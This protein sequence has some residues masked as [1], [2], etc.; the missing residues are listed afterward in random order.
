MELHNNDVDNWVCSLTGTHTPTEPV[1]DAFRE[2]PFT[3]LVSACVIGWATEGNAGRDIAR[4][5]TIPEQAPEV[6]SARFLDRFRVSGEQ[7][8]DMIR[9]RTGLVRKALRRDGKPM[10]PRKE[11]RRMLL[12]T[13]RRS[14]KE[15]SATRADGGEVDA[16]DDGEGKDEAEGGDEEAMDEEGA[17]APA[18]ADAPAEA[19]AAK[20]RS[21]CVLYLCVPGMLGLAFNCLHFVCLIA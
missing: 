16:G 12:T 20:S 17:T 7:C 1:P 5:I 9:K 18:A 8:I 13:P 14:K 11:I 6:F 15:G 21:V 3:P 2:L 4:R 19:S 10:P